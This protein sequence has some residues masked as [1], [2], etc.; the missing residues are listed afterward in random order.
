MLK[1]CKGDLQHRFDAI[2]RKPSHD[3]GGHARGDRIPHVRR[4][5]VFGEQHDR[6]A[7]VA[8]GHHDVLERVAGLTLG[9]DDDHVGPDLCQPL[10]Q[11]HI[12]GQNGDDVAAVLQ[13]AYAQ[14]SGA[15]RLALFN[16]VRCGVLRVARQERVGG[17]DDDAQ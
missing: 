13:Q 17:D 9:V 5:V 4:V 11:E 3:I 10:G 7:R 15:L 14:G 8:G 2:R 1:P 6:P 12:G 16:G